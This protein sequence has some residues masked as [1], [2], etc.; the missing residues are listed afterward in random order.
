[1]FTAAC[2]LHAASPDV[3]ALIALRFLQGAAG[4]AGIVITRAVVRDLF[5]G[6]AAARRF[7]RLV[8]IIGLAPIPAPIVGGQLLH[9]TDRHG[10]FLVLAGIGLAL[11]LTTARV[12]PETLPPSARHGGGL[13][14]SV[15]V[16]GE[17]LHDRSFVG[18]IVAHAVCFGAVFAHI[19]GSAFVVQDIFHASPHAFNAVSATNAAGRSS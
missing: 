18:V 16:V 12:L 17:L 7:G 14:H 19:S 3:S 8:L 4:V 6:P 15:S 11:T 5:E 10:I 9:V 1:M 2:A 13:P